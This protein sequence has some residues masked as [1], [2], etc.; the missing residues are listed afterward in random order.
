METGALTAIGTDEGVVP[1]SELKKVA[2][3]THIA[4]ALSR[5]GRFRTMVITRG[6]DIR[7]TPS[8]ENEVA[9]RI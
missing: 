4:K 7:T 8:L 2:K 1:K 5:T 3:K 6:L 9:K